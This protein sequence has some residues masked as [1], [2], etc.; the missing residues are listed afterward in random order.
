M[1]DP[2]YVEL[3][4][5]TPFKLS[6]Y[7]HGCLRFQAQNTVWWRLIKICE[8]FLTPSFFFFFCKLK[9]DS[10]PMKVMQCLLWREAKIATISLLLPPGLSSSVQLSDS[11]QL[12]LQNLFSHWVVSSTEE[13]HKYQ[14]VSFQSR[15]MQCQRM[16]HQ[17][18]CFW[19]R[20]ISVFSKEH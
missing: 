8:R 2:F 19:L 9:T 14:L 3:R 12:S 4:R 10:M 20:L 17:I 15:N 18:L 5:K 11:Q 6:E 16:K 1:W 13:R 7:K